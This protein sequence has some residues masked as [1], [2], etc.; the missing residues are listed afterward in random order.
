ML[1]RPGRRDML[2]GEAELGAG[3]RGGRDGAEISHGGHRQTAV[4]PPRKRQSTR[5]SGVAGSPTAHHNCRAGL[6]LSA[7]GDLHRPRFLS[8]MIRP[9]EE[10]LDPDLIHLVRALALDAARRDHER[11]KKSDVRGEN[12]Q[13]K[14]RRSPPS[15]RL[16][17]IGGRR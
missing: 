6:A 3:A 14:R 13:G 7:P 11:C 15:K 17:S 12:S 1:R 5:S 16:P 8:K 4:S 2:G 10:S 9:L